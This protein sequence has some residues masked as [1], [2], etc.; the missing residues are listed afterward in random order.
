MNK[1]QKIIWTIYLFLLLTLFIRA[2]GGLRDGNEVLHAYFVLGW[3]PFL[4]AHFIWREKKSKEKLSSEGK[5]EAD[6]KKKNDDKPRLRIRIRAYDH[7]IL[8]AS[9][10]Q[11]L[12]TAERYG[13]QLMG[14]VPLPTDI[15]KYTVNRSTF[16]HKDAREQFEMRTHKRLMDILENFVGL[17]LQEEIRLQNVKTW[18]QEAIF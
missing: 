15:R 2:V 3:I 6:V 1:A 7:K 16:V 9:V 17:F 4:I 5:K 14:P 8:D 18:R 11:I 12:D 10:K 13:A